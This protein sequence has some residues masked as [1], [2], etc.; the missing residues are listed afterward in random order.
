MFL[1][2]DFWQKMKVKMISEGEWFS[3]VLH[4]S[5][6]RIIAQNTF[7]CRKCSCVLISREN[8][9]TQK[10]NAAETVAHKHALKVFFTFLNF[11]GKQIQTEKAN[12]H[13]WQSYTIRNMLHNRRVSPQQTV[14]TETIKNEVIKFSFSAENEIT[15]E[16]KFHG[17]LS[18]T[19]LPLK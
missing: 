10:I 11:G 6:S 15:V 3:I 7:H 5:S 1:W 14:Q 18:N 13:F 9:I 12:N 16:I 19:N 17:K 8:E 4:L 2:S